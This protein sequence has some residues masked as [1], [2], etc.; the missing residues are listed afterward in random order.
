VHVGGASGQQSLDL[1]G[2]ALRSS[3]IALM[4]SGMR[5]VSMA[6]LLNAVKN[7]FDLSAQLRIDTRTAP[8]SQVGELWDAPGKPRLVFEIA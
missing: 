5:S 6:A 7:I 8:L 4:G 1:P 2:V 3:G